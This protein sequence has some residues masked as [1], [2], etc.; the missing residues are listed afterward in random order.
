MISD[1]L[2]HNLLPYKLS[3]RIIHCN[4]TWTFHSDHIGSKPLFYYNDKSTFIAAA[5]F[6][7]LKSVIQKNGVKLNLNIQA[8]YLLLTYGYVFEDITIASQ[9]KRL[10]V[11]YSLTLKK[12]QILLERYHKIYFNYQK[13]SLIDAVE[14]L[15]EKFQK[16]I[17][18]AFDKDIEYG[19]K[20]LCTLS[21][22]LDSRM[23]S[24]V[25]HELGYK[26]Q[27]NITFSQSNYLDETIAKKIASDY[28][29]D[30]IFKSLDNGNFLF[31]LDDV[32][33]MTGGNVIYYGSA[34][35]N[36]MYKNINFDDYGILHTGQLGDVSIGTY[37]S[38]TKN[39]KFRMGD[40]AYSNKLI[41]R[42]NDF[43]FSE[44]YTNQEE[45]KMIIR[46]FYGTNLGLLGVQ[47]YTET[48]SPFYDID[49]LEF[50]LSV[51]LEMR[52]HHKLY[53]EWILKKHP[54]A[55]NYIW[56][57]TGTKINSPFILKYKNHLIPFQ[58]IP[59][60]IMMKLNILN[61]KVNSKKSMNPLN[62]WYLTNSK[63]KS[64]MDSYVADNLYLIENQ[65]LRNDANTLYNDSGLTGKNQVL[66]LLA[67][68]KYLNS[69]N[70]I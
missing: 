63:L 7:N 54:R 65:D 58:Q 51:P 61:N 48:Y 15:N 34:H 53:K 1:V 28:K 40:G 59:L 37:A 9:I 11:G 35:S 6:D 45:F 52:M 16:A 3:H 10:K 66:T 36:S 38:T 62:Y 50:V 24:I 4:K 56:E 29:H 21:G 20:H 23:T 70:N 47:K 60:K 19:Y 42:L 25:A 26:Q 32:T 43:K 57:K 31:D 41:N 12:S 33:K 67:A 49:F 2:D 17:T 22:G 30:W 68:N 64:Y 27:M 39:V 8:A 69:S 44:D 13:I 5:S 18:S 55:A 14:T 46:G